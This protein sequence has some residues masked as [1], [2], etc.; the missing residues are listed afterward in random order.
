MSNNEIRKYAINVIVIYGIIMSEVCDVKWYLDYIKYYESLKEN[1]ER[2][3]GT[4]EYNDIMKNDRLLHDCYCCCKETI[5]EIEENQPK[6]YYDNVR[7]RN[8][9]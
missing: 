8:F 2:I 7:W 9:V 1:I 5:E 3:K 6:M 4:T